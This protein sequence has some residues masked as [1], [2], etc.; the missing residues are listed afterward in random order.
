MFVTLLCTR[1]QQFKYSVGR[2]SGSGLQISLDPDPVSAPVSQS[3]K[4][5]AERA[6]KINLLEEGP[7]KNEKKATVS[8]SKLS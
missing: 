6:V 1:M 5:S 4:K 2:M 3:K 8:Y 7:S